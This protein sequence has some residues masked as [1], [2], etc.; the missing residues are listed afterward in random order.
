M[1]SLPT[2]PEASC[3]LGASFLVPKL[4]HDKIDVSVLQMGSQNS[5]GTQPVGEDVKT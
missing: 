1:H 4:S 5:E 3:L 2:N